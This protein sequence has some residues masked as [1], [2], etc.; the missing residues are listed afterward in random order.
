[1]FS[2]I[3]R[4]FNYTT[5]AAT[6]AL[7]FA[8]SGGAYAAG[9][10]LITSTKQISPKVLK[11][12]TGKTGPAGPAGKAG[13]N[14]APGAQGEKGAAGTNGTNGSNG[15]NGESVT[16]TVLARGA[17]CKEGGAEFKVGP[18]AATHVCNGEK[19]KE[20]SPWTPNNSLPSGAIETGTWGGNITYETT[21]IP[22]S[23]PI[24]LAKA[25]VES[26]VHIINSE[27][28]EKEAKESQAIA[29]GECKG[30]YISP[31]AAS[32]NLCVFVTPGLGNA[33]EISAIVDFNH[34][35]PELGAGT[36]GTLLEI[37]MGSAL[38]GEVILGTW[39]MTAPEEP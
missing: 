24:P 36:T 9:K 23:F 25:M 8:M 3:R 31:A 10:Y 20:G 33:H 11:A 29:K 2:T 21:D 26:Q 22:I 32:G 35:P 39:A 15:Q 1:M 13:A 14:G 7:V 6:L 30:T 12:L 27:E 4:N 16:N 19:G 37:P 5:V 38:A 17:T 34:S 18:G 28:G